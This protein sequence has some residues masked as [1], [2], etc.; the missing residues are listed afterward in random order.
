MAASPGDPAPLVKRFVALVNR[1]SAGESTAFMH[2]SGLTM[3]QI[4][5]LHA[6]RRA[7]AS[8]TGLAARLRR[9]LPA[10]SQLV[11]R[12]VEAGLVDRA[13]NAADRRVRRVTILPA[14]QRFL[15]RLG[16]MR[17]REIE[18]ALRSVSPGARAA[19]AAAM[20]QVVDEL[21]RELAQVPAQPLPDR[22]RRARSRP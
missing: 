5:V 9:S 8:I 18:D 17:L 4:V 16:E 6:L 22:R 2:A 7:E 21:E 20:A 14:G 10:T 3:P 13:E 19:L 1:K 11:D 12:L 15:E